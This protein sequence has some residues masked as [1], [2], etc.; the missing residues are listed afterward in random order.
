MSGLLQKACLKNKKS[1]EYLEIRNLKFSP[2]HLYPLVRFKNIIS[3]LSGIGIEA[4]HICQ[5]TPRFDYNNT[6]I[7]K[8]YLSDIMLNISVTATMLYCM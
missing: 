7:S 2:R 3:R 6:I 1:G 4:S 8:V 5:M